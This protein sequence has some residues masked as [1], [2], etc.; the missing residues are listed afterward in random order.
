MEA[1]K[2]D[3]T[4]HMAYTKLAA[5]LLFQGKV[6]EAEKLYRQYKSEFKDN[7]L[8]DFAEFERLGIIP[9]ERKKDVER[10]KAMLNEE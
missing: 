4:Q 2:V 7:Y 10:I 9:K 6:N 8:D 3:S 1:L 5:A